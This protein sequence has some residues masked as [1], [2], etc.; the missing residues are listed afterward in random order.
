VEDVISGYTGGREPYPTFENKRDHKE[1]I[2]I[3]FD[4]NILCFDEVLD[5]FLERAGL[6]TS[7]RCSETF[8]PT[9]Y[10]HNEAQ[11]V[12]AE[13]VARIIARTRRHSVPAVVPSG[14]FYQA[15]EYHQ[16]FIKKIRDSETTVGSSV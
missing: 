12:A 14:D 13:N 1:A 8:A 5:H 15:E 16:R 11:R 4:P 9:I 7:L 6:V 3:V 10:A 2:R